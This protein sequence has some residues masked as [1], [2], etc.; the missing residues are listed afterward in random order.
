VKGLSVDDERRAWLWRTV[1]D[2]VCGEHDD[3]WA[4]AVCAAAG[5]ALGVDAATLTLYSTTGVQELLAVSDE[6]ARTAVALR[7]RC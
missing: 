3:G 4:H 5:P 7:Y 2:H 1:S 6:W